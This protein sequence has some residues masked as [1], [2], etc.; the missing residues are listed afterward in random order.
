[1]YVKDSFEPDTFL[2]ILCY[3]ISVCV[4]SSFFTKGNEALHLISM[5]CENI[6]VADTQWVARKL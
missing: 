1:M 6:V 3:V 2:S 4:T 5:V